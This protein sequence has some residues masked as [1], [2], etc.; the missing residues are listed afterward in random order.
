[1]PS[2]A[3]DVWI[4]LLLLIIFYFFFSRVSLSARLKLDWSSYPYFIITFFLSMSLYLLPLVINPIKEGRML[5]ILKSWCLSV[6]ERMH[7]SEEKMLST[8]K[9]SFLPPKWPSPPKITSLC[10]WRKVC[11]LA[12]QEHGESLGSPAHTSFSRFLILILKWPFSVPSEMVRKA[13]VRNQRI[14]MKVDNSKLK[15]KN[16][17]CK[18][19]RE[20]QSNRGAGKERTILLEEFL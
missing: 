16:T 13:I 18:T 14:R 3:N 5:S 12:Q 20:S 10:T 15:P 7:V 19:E 8:D 17:S 9:T 11:L 1:M 6:E 2:S 4:Q